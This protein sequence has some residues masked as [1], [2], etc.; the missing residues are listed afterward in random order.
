MNKEGKLDDIALIKL[1]NAI[2][3]KKGL[4]E[5]IALPIRASNWVS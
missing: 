5:P 1:K 4:V 3:F 2:E